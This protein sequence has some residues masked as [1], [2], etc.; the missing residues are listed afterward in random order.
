MLNFPNA[1]LRPIAI[2]MPSLS[3]AYRIP[4]RFMLK[5]IIAS[6]NNEFYFSPDQLRSQLESGKF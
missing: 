1:R 4:T 5:V 6:A 3:F 2:P